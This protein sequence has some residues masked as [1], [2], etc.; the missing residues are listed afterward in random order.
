M[1]DSQAALFADLAPGG[2]IADVLCNATGDTN[3]QAALVKAGEIL[4]AGRPLAT[5]EIYFV[6]DG[7]PNGG[8]EGVAEADTLKNVGVNVGSDFLTVTIATVMLGGTD[9]ILEQQ[10][11]SKDPSGKPLHAYVAQTSQL[12]KV[13]TD[14]AANG[15]AG[16]SI[17]YRPIGTTQYT[18]LSLLDH[19]Q[20]FDFTLPSISIG[21]DQ[22]P[23]GL[24]VLLEYYDRHDNRYSSGG[25]LL[26]TADDG[27]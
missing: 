21:M 8:E 10:I 9:Q 22:A 16:G 12:T 6:S 4:T 27:V 5:K 2:N 26:W 7:Q 17:K 19:V 11:A 15:I 18:T 14:L 25:K 23:N 13:L 20:G 24:E 3:Y 1:F